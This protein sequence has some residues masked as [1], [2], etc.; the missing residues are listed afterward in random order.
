MSMMGCRYCG[1]FP[2]KHSSRC[3]SAVFRGGRIWRCLRN[4]GHS[5]G[6]RYADDAPRERGRARAETL[7]APAVRP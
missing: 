1:E 2:E 3:R 4:R 7:T 6:C 5:R